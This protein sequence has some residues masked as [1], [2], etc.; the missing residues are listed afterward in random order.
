MPIGVYP[1]KS[2]QERFNEKWK[3]DKR[4][5]CH[6]WKAS[7]RGKGYG[8]FKLNYKNTSAHRVAYELAYGPIP[9]SMHVCHKC[10]NPPCVNPKHLWLGTNEENI[11]DK[12]NKGRY[13]AARGSDNGS[14]KVTE[15]MAIK[16][17]W[18]YSTGKHTQTRLATRFN[19]S[20]GAVGQLIRKET[21][22]HI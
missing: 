14:A 11:E 17:R 2:L 22:K 19:I 9:E 18:L 3:L 20:R 16:I 6:V 7:T 5:G 1:R 4:S 21:W 8:Q 10:D 13:N 12:S 15:K